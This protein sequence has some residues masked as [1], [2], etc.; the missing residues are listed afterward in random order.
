MEPSRQPIDAG[1]LYTKWLCFANAGMLDRGNLYLMDYALSR[2]KSNSPMIEIGSFC[3]LS[4]NILTHFKRKYGLKNRLITCDK[5]DFENEDKDRIHVAGSPVLF[6]EYREFVRDSYLRSTC[7][8]SAYDLPY[9]M[10]VLS[11][12]FFEKWKKGET[13][14][15]VRGRVLQLGGPI[16]FCYIDGNHT[17]EGAKHDF[18]KCDAFLEPGGFVLFDDSA[19]PTFGV[20]RVMPEVLATDG[21]QLV[22]IN[23]NHLFQK[24]P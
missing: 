9:T 5:W 8:F 15:D 14:Q 3:G 16:S 1:D 2:I 24:V 17:Y 22:A 12:E 20:W 7:L 23:P 18:L 21:Y 10:E 11:D 6:S 19:E 13:V 4:A